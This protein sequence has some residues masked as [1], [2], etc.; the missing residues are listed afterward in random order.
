MQKY[1][2]KENI[3][4]GYNRTRHI[5]EIEAWRISLYTLFSD[6]LN[7]DIKLFQYF[8]IPQA[9]FNFLVD[10]LKPH[11]LRQSNKVNFFVGSNIRVFLYLHFFV[12]LHNYYRLRR[13]HDAK[14]QRQRV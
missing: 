13:L 1:R 11:I 14:K 2:K 12:F 8:R 3:I 9:K 5:Q 6:L 4:S 10:T 7:D